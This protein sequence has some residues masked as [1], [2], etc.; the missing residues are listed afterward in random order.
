MPLKRLQMDKQKIQC[1]KD[2]SYT[3]K[4]LYI[5]KD[6]CFV[7]KKYNPEKILFC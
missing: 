3:N 5:I 7:S 6:S 2:L 4:K 1:G